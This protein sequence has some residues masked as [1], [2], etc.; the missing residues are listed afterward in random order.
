MAEFSPTTKQFEDFAFKCTV[1]VLF[2][3]VCALVDGYDGVVTRKSRVLRLAEDPGQFWGALV[4]AWGYFGMLALIA[5][6]AAGVG[7]LVLKGLEKA[8]GDQ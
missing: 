4:M 5:A 3:A 8:S 2:T 1:A 7:A 6:I